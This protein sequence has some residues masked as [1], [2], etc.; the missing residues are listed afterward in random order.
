MKTSGLNATR[1]SRGGCKNYRGRLTSL[2]SSASI[3]QPCWRFLCCSGVRSVIHW[4]RDHRI[5]HKTTAGSHAALPR[6]HPWGC[7]G[8]RPTCTAAAGIDP[9]LRKS[10]ATESQDSSVQGV[11]TGLA[12]SKQPLWDLHGALKCPGPT[13]RVRTQQNPTLNQQKKQGRYPSSYP[14]SRGEESTGL[15]GAVLPL[16]KADQ[17]CSQITPRWNQ[18]HGEREGVRAARLQPPPQPLCHRSLSKEPKARAA[19]IKPRF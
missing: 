8:A 5:T 1:N 17:A 3:N 7:S 11:G 12:Q 15:S 13:P 4:R 14:G 6:A 2:H 10:N 19:L 16:H 18:L 9:P